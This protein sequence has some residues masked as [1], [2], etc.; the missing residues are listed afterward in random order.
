MS[1]VQRSRIAILFFC[2]GLFCL[3]QQ[4]RAYWQSRDSNYNINIV[5][6][7]A[8]N[9][10]IDGS[11]HVNQTV[12]NPVTITLSTTQ[13]NDVIAFCT[14]TNGGPIVGGSVTDTALLSWSKRVSR[15][16]GGTDLELWWAPSTGILT[17]DVITMT[18]TGTAFTT[19]DAFAIHG[20][21]NI[22]APWD[23][24]GPQN[25]ATDP[26]SITTAN[27]ITMVLGCFRGS[28]ASP[29]A[30]AGYTI[31]S[32]ADFQMTERRTFTTVQTALS[33]TVGTGVGTANGSI[34]DAID[35]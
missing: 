3:S 12:V 1:W 6:S 7:G 2:L 26:I 24:G 28:T 5:A 15:G 22:A 21:T 8:N 30:G 14:T 35:Q 18:L 34:A 10:T 29:T 9:L 31:I 16:T 25:S 17:S 32:G 13:T 20:A 27:A 11:A 23:S 4:P 19:V 33:V